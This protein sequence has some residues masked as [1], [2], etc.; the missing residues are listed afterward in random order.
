MKVI[1]QNA[2][3]LAL[4]LLPDEA[5]VEMLAEKIVVGAHGNYPLGFI[6]LC[7]N[8]SDSTL[9]EDVTDS[10]DDWIGNKYFYD[11][12]WSE[13]TDYKIYVAPE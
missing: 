9:Y 5:S 4:F 1:S 13:N 3:N 10:P 6:I 11:G 12:N 8:S 2:T 7:N